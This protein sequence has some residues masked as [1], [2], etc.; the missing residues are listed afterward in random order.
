MDAALGLSALL[1]GL[2]GTPHCLAMCAPACGAVARGCGGARPARAMAT[3]QATRLVSYAAGGALVAGS[4]SA[5]AQWAPSVAWLRPLWTMLHLAALLVGM[6]MLL[7]AS[8]PAWLGAIGRG[9]VHVIALPRGRRGA[10]ARAGLPQAAFAGLLWVAWPCGLLQS[11]LLVA[12]LASGPAAGA[13]VMAA[14]AL[15]SGVGLVAGPLLWARLAGRERAGRW[16][17][18]TVRIAGAMLA[19]ASLWAL[20]PGVATSVAQFCAG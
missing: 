16:H 10:V 4:V 18:A 17:A 11:A 15:G 7:R 3:L 8:Q 13:A 5:L 6:S 12:A 2:A 1:M 9:G 14:F 19:A 20:L